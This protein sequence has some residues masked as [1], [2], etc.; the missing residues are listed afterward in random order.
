MKEKEEWLGETG[1]LLFWISELDFSGLVGTQL[2]SSES[3][4]S[5][6]EVEKLGCR[7]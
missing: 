4:Y 6:K 3:L 1:G 5:H 7:R 2:L